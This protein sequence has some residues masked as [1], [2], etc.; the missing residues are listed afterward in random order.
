MLRSGLRLRHAG[1]WYDPETMHHDGK[2]I[3]VVQG[4]PHTAVQ[5]VFRA[6]VARWQSSARIVGVIA[7][8]HDLGER[9]CSAG[10]LRSL[11]DGRLF[12]MFQDL[13]SQSTACHL[14]AAGVTSASEAVT[15]DIAA[16][17]DLVVLS[18]FGKLEAARG[19]LAS[20]FAAAIA[21]GVPVLTTVSSALAE[22]WAQFAAPLFTALP[23][24][25]VAIDAWWCE[26]RGVAPAT[27]PV[28]RV[29]V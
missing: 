11:A 10:Y 1:L 8:D 26:V 14:D 17:C 23:A 22:R 4:G 20:A 7:Q 25:P 19:G 15:H 2:I 3:A 16:G 9:T 21:A 29:S 27:P 12:P 24:D 5:E 28:A 6:F 18:K 13:G